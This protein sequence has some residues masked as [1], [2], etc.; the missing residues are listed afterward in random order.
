MLNSRLQN[1]YRNIGFGFST[2][3]LGL[4]VE[5]SVCKALV[6]LEHELLLFKELS[7]LLLTLEHTRETLA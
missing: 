5:A 4:C 3:W 2:L 7:V 1:V 6:E